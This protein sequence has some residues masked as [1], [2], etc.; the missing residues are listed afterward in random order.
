MENTSGQ[1]KTASVPEGI[2]GWSWGA[3]LLNWIWAVFN[4][5]WIGLLVF[6]PLIGF[7]MTFV[8]GFK[9]R[10]WAWRNKRWDSVEHFNRVQK[11]W[12]FWGVILGF[13]WIVFILGILAAVA[14]PAYKSYQIRVQEAEAKMALSAQAMPATSDAKPSVLTPPVTA[15]APSATPASIAPSAATP[16]STVATSGAIQQP[17]VKEN[18]TPSPASPIAVTNVHAAPVQTHQ[19]PLATIAVADPKASAKSPRNIN[20]AVKKPA[21]RPMSHVPA[22]RRDCLNLSSNAAIAKC[23]GE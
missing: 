22:D 3:F 18:A 20:S 9:G 1:G 23:A 11:K 5:T 16:S 17:P 10:E 21:S 7:I 4:R 15:S 8:L 14:I 19:P 13:V 2:K 6:V 12:S